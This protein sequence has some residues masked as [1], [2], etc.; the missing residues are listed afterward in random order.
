MPPTL[1]CYGC[2]GNSHFLSAVIESLDGTLEEYFSETED[3]KNDREFF[4]K[5]PALTRD[6]R[7]RAFGGGEIVGAFMLFVVT[8]FGKKVFDEFY[9]RLLKRPLAPFFDKLCRSGGSSSDQPIEFID[10]AYLQ[11][12][13]LVV[14]IRVLVTAD[15]AK[16][17]AA[18]VV[19]AHRVA[20]SYIEHNGRKAPVHC[21]TI[22]E[23]KVS[24]EPVLYRSLEHQAQATRPNCPHRVLRGVRVLKR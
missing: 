22:T 18:L 15:T 3:W 8:C 11:D 5:V 7:P 13:D 16:D 9:E 6:V 2:E 24:L 4:S 17:T 10:I 1:Y 19:E 20:H 14:V 21:H 12:I 23:G